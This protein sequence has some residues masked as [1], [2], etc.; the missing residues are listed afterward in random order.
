ML[1]LHLGLKENVG[2][3]L[4]CVRGFL[5]MFASCTWV[6]VIDHM[7]SFTRVCISICRFYVELYGF[8]T[9]LH[10][11]FFCFSLLGSELDGNVMEAVQLV[12]IRNGWRE[13]VAYLR[14]KGAM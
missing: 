5:Q 1:Y 9:G 3:T 8:S 2:F 6:F 14:E 7:L 4:I 13:A 11:C 12:S 10:W